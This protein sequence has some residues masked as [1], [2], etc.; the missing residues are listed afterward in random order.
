MSYEKMR[1]QENELETI[2][3]NIADGIRI[4]SKLVVE[5]K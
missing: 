2:Y 3:D 4:R 5:E 1:K